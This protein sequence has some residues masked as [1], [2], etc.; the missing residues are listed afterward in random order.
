M[1]V[2]ISVTVHSI[3]SVQQSVKN[4]RDRLSSDGATIGRSDSPIVTIVLTLM[5]RYI[6]RPRGRLGLLRLFL[7][8][9]FEA[10]STAVR[11]AVTYTQKQQMNELEVKLDLTT[12][13]HSSKLGLADFTDRDSGKCNAIDLVRL[14]VRLFPHYLLHRLTLELSFC[15]FM[16][17]DQRMES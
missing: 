8:G 1:S 7:D 17:H 9:H 5:H 4:Y 6:Y 2:H 14:S 15:M 13:I 11:R 3:L 12:S 16:G 10:V